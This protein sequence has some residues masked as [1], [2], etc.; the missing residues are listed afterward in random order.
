LFASF[1]KNEKCQEK[2]KQWHL[3]FKDVPA[4]IPGY[5]YDAGNLVM[6]ASASGAP[7]KFDIEQSAREL[8][9]KI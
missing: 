9:R 1:S 5:K 3:K 4:E 6:G 2:Q 8:D 7:N